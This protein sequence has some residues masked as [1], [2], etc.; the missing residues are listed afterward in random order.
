MPNTFLALEGVA[1]EMDDHEMKHIM[2]MS[3]PPYRCA[4]QP[5]GICTVGVAWCL[6]STQARWC[7]Y[8]GRPEHDGQS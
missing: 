3:L 6:L 8:V 4:A 5:P 2:S 1:T 7:S